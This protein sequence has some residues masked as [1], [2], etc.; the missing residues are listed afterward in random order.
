MNRRL[1]LTAGIAVTA[2]AAGAGFAWWRGARGTALTEAEQ[3][4]WTQR[5]EQPGGGEIVMAPW[6]GK[7]LVLNFWATWCAPCVKEMP[8]LDAFHRQHQAN[9]WQV[10]GLAIDGPTPVREFLTKVPVGFP[11]G[12]AGFTGV[13]L[14]RSLGNERGGLPFSVI[15]DRRGAVAFR[16]LGILEPAELT[17]WVAQLG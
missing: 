13:D 2:A 14:A 1:A 15:F 9:G 4:L 3:A 6:Q 11:I 5:F 10:V 7:P 8:M 17:H 16:K 12:L